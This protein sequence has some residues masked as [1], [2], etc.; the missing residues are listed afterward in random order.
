MIISH[1]HKFIFIKTEKTAGTSIEIALSQLCGSNDI[2]T[3]IS[4]I[5]EKYRKELGYRTKQN[6]SIPL[7]KF[8]KTDLLDLLFNRKRAA[9]YNHIGASEIRR[10][11]EPKHWDEYY[12]FTFERNPF[13]K[14]ISYYYWRGGEEKYPAVQDFINSGKAA[15]IKG[16]DLYTQNS[17]IVVDK[18]YKYEE[19]TEALKDIGTRLNLNDPLKLPEKKAK[20]NI[21]KK[22]SSYKNTLSRSEKKWVEQVFARELKFFD[23]SF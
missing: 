3:P 22:S 7:S 8:D 16:F 1:K 10:Y 23:Y 15:K 18:V 9:F 6:Y 4:E 11:I 12:K 5:D 19:L 17:E 20:G 14:L 13:D 2:I 21:R